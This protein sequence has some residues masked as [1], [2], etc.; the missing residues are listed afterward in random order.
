MK[1]IYYLHKP[2]QW[3]YIDDPECS[4]FLI[5]ESGGGQKVPKSLAVF[6]NPQDWE[7]VTTWIDEMNEA[8]WINRVIHQALY[9][10]IF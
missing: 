10:D 7:I 1:K 9:S 4:V 6:G 3:V 8:E 2:T 5:P